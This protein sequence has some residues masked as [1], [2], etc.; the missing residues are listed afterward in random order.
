MNDGLTITDCTKMINI[1]RVL[2]VKHFE[3]PKKAKMTEKTAEGVITDAKKR[4]GARV[5]Q[6][7]ATQKQT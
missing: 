1:R 2:S 3:T 4:Y 6:L 5:F 7:A